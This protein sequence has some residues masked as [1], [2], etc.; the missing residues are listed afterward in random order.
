M[1]T[2]FNPTIQ[3]L[4]IALQHF[5]SDFPAV[6][7]IKDH[8]TTSSKKRFDILEG[9]HIAIIATVLDP[10]VKFDFCTEPNSGKFFTFTRQSIYD[11]VVNYFNRELSDNYE[12]ESIQN[13]VIETRTRKLIVFAVVTK[14]FKKSW[15]SFLINDLEVDSIALNNPIFYW[16]EAV[17]EEKF[18]TWV[19]K[20]LSLPASSGSVER[21]FSQSNIR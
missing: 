17:L 19:F 2:K 14:K 16:K 7:C 6:N 1:I 20:I 11:L 5:R 3:Q 21:L 18:R 15:R 12:V 8:F 4:E 13:D 9:S 10:A